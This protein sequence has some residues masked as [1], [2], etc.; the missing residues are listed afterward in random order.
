MASSRV[1]IFIVLSLTMTTVICQ[2]FQ[3]SHGWTNGKRSSSMLE[4]MANSVG[5][6]AGQLDNVLVECER[7]KLRSLLQGNINSQVLQ[8]LPCEFFAYPRRNFLEPV[9]NA[10]RLQRRSTPVKN[11]Y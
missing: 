6:N 2:T 8:E 10:D 3:Y 7:Q 11:N 9:A 4:E 5:K 1:L